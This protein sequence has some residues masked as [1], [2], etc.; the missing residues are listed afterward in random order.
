MYTS[1]V[2]YTVDLN[3][4]GSNGKRIRRHASSLLPS[5]L[6]QAKIPMHTR[7][8]GLLLLQSLP[9]SDVSRRDDGL[10][11]RL[12][13]ASQVVQHVPHR[14]HQLAELHHHHVCRHLAVLKGREE[15]DL[16][17]TGCG[18]S[19]LPGSEDAGGDDGRPGRPDGARQVVP[20][21]RT[22]LDHLAELDHHDV[23]RG[24]AELDKMFRFFF[25]FSGHEKNGTL[26]KYNM[27]EY[28]MI[29]TTIT[30]V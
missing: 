6:Q 18:E 3:K 19:F 4:A 23:G 13:R 17:E 1:R 10:P 24:V 30:T 21:V 26:N 16:I 20:Q 12:H 9:R 29:K 2:D 15:R 8:Q 28:N 14:L 22:G 7:G 25:L 27:Y 11:R 5:F